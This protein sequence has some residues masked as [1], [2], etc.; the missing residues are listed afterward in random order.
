MPRVRTPMAVIH[1][2]VKMDS[3]VLVWTVQTSTNV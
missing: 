2:R 3:M 1:V